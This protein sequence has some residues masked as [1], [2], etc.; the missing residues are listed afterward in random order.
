MALR[1]SGNPSSARLAR[2]FVRGAAESWNSDP[3]AVS[4]LTWLT[5]EVVSNAILHAGGGVELRVD[6]RGPRVRVEVDDQSSDLPERRSYGPES[7]TGRGLEVVAALASAWGVDALPKGKT[8][9]FETGGERRSKSVSAPAPAIAAQLRDGDL[10]P[11]EIA[12]RGIPV[13]AYLNAQQHKDELLR[14]FTFIAQSGVQPGAVPSRLVETARVGRIAFA[15]PVADNRVQVNAAVE[16][17]DDTVDLT[18]SVPR[19]AGPFAERLAALLDEADEYCRAGELLTLAATPEIRRFRAWF[20]GQ[21]VAQ[22]RDE[23]GTA[24]ADHHEASHD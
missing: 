14:E 20:F 19:V 2:A 24:W 12:I 8:V 22:L 10:Q 21:V 16:R 6:R 3:E 13:Q 4:N 15:G 18:F 9:W 17:G 11:K 1:L 7:A 5:S 23:P